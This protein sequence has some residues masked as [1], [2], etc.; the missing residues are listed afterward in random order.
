M[1]RVEDVDVFYG[2]SHI[3]HGIEMDIQHGQIVALLGRNGVGKTTTIKTI[4]GIL[5]PKK[6]RI[7]FEGQE[8]SKIPTHEIARIGIS[9]V[10]QGRRLFNKLTVLE[11]IIIGLTVKKELRNNESYQDK[12]KKVLEIFPQLESLL[13]RPVETLSGGEQQM[14]AIARA[15]VTNP[16]LLLMDEPSE[17]LMPVLV[18]KL[19]DTIKL[20]NQMGVTILLTEQNVSM[21]LK[22]ADKVYIMDNGEIRFKGNPTRLLKDED[23]LLKYLGV[24]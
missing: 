4:I 9:Y 2:K 20:I 1:L 15:L 23:L 13:N 12:I 5:K 8:I 16:K 22:I 21:A 17:G 6:G 11:N 24:R 18:Q 14:V 7:I 19:G 3:L 10:P